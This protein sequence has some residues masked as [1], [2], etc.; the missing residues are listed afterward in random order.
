MTHPLALVLVALLGVPA[1]MNPAPPRDALLVSAT[2]LAQR[3]EDPGLVLLHVGDRADYTSGHI[4]GARHV[5][6]GDISISTAP[7]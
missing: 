4:E 2:Q 3:L 1:P 7:V 6:L 5:S